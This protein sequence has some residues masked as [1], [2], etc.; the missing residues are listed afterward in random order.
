MKSSSA[1]RV[2]NSWTRAIDN[3]DR[4]AGLFG[5]RHLIAT[6]SFI[7][8]MEKIISRT[9]DC[10]ILTG[11]GSRVAHQQEK[12]LVTNSL[13]G[14]LNNQP[15]GGFLNKFDIYRTLWYTTALKC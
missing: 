13:T 15:K 14:S 4:R 3:N 11:K 7:L 8:R 5:P 9:D 2:L 6:Q 10:S 12:G 1:I